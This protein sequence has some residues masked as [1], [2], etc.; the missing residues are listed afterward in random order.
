MSTP[1]PALLWETGG[2]SMKNRIKSRKLSFYHHLMT[3]EHSS[4]ASRVARVADRAGYPGLMKEYKSLCLELDLP[5]PSKV[6]K[7]SWKRMVKKAIYEA[8]KTNL[9]RSMKNLTMKV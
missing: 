4:V 7:H 2:L 9:L 8:N 6:S 5:C 1:T 3:L